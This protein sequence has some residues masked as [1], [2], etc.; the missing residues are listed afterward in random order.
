MIKLAFPTHPII[1]FNLLFLA[2]TF[3][4]PASAHEVEGSLTAKAGIGATDLFSVSCANDPEFSGGPAQQLF[5]NVRDN[6]KKGGLMSVVAY[7]ATANGGI[8][9]TAT[10]PKGGD[11]NPSPDIV[12]SGGEGD[13][14]VFV[15]HTEAF[16]ESYMLQFHCQDAAKQHTG[17]QVQP[18]QN[19]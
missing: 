4:M 18:L 6:D 5:V 19:E 7:K 8:S 11:Y 15:N 3:I 16:A 10:D 2:T 14:L 17:T 1:I 9:K 13:Y 12:L